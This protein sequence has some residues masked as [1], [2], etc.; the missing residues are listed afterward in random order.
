MARIIG[1]TGSGEDLDIQSTSDATR[2]DINVPAGERLVVVDHATRPSLNVTPRNAPPTNASVNDIYLD[3]GT[4]TSSTNPGWRR[5]VST[6]PDVWNDISA[7]A[8]GFSDHGALAGLA[9]DDHSQYGL[10]AGRAG[11]QVL[12][13]GTASGDDVEIRSTSHGTKGDAVIS[14]ANLHRLSTVDQQ[15]DLGVS[16]TSFVRKHLEWLSYGAGPLGW[17]TF[18]TIAPSAVVGIYTRGLIRVRVSYVKFNFGYFTGV[19]EA[20]RYFE[21]NNAAP[22]TGVFVANV[23]VGNAPQ[24]RLNINGNNIEL[25]VDADDG[26]S[27][28]KGLSEVEVFAPE[29]Y[30]GGLTYTLT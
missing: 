10:L 2:G 17:S 4:N 14:Q 8:S 24:F 12:T 20:Y 19:L 23:T 3:D 15:L 18:L 27:P 5:C 21:I 9:D 11:G 1:G 22:T 6:G 25:Q 29:D 13:G 30:A 16:N 28:W 7:S 26:S